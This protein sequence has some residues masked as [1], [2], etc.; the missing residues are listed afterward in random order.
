MDKKGFTTE[1]GGRQNG[2]S[3]EPEINVISEG[4]SRKSFI[5]FSLLLITFIVGVIYYMQIN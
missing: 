5:I 3:L 2:F 4:E 1:S